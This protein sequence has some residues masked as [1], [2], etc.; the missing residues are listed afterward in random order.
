MRT[1]VL[2]A[3]ALVAFAGNSVLC[4][5]ALGEG[6]IDAASF[7]TLRLASGAAVL[8]VAGLGRPR[9]S[10][11]PSWTSAL[12]LVLYALPFSYAY[13]LVTTG[14]GA[15]LLF[16]SVQVTMLLA[17]W[18]GGERLAPTQWI[19]VALAAAGLVTLVRPGLAAPPPL[20]AALMAAAG[21]SWGLYSLKG[22]QAGDPVARNAAA[23][24]YATPLA[25]LAGVAVLPW[26]HVSTR[27]ALLAAASGGLTSGLGYVAWYAALP[28]L[29]A[30]R[31]SLVQLLVP[32]LAAAGGLLVLGEPVTRRLVISAA[33]V[34]G[35]L[36]LV[37]LDRPRA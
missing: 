2:T 10:G 24:L 5:L 20:G 36:V 25:L 16:G 28:G 19:G 3:A 6:S 33:V 27:G 14:A 8:L 31:A 18:R 13:G 4:R 23:F 21:V 35:G 1:V 37:L 34:A 7:S 11:A 15:L 12:V 9:T 22:R 26:L 29:T 17:A 30:A 32:V